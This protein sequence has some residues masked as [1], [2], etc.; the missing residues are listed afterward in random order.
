MKPDR[1]PF[2]LVSFLYG[3]VAKWAVRQSPYHAPDGLV[4]VLIEF[5]IRITNRECREKLAGATHEFPY[6]EAIRADH[7]TL[8][9]IL[10]EDLLTLPR[11]LLWNE[12]KN[13]NKS[14]YGFTSRYSQPHPDDDFIDL[15]ALV[16]NITID[17]IKHDRESW[18]MD[19]PRHWWEIN[20]WNRL[21]LRLQ[22]KSMVPSNLK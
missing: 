21:K 22:L 16:R 11:V 8:N 7:E 18:E 5:K 2:V 1:I 20:W 12:R 4:A 9:K 14:P 19:R 6:P 10:R 17:C 15:D 3:E 13:G